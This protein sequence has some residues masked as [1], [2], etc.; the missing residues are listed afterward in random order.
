MGLINIGLFGLNFVT[1]GEA[2][3][4]RAVGEESIN[5]MKNWKTPGTWTTPK[6][7]GLGGSGE[8]RQ[9]GDNLIEWVRVDFGHKTGGFTYP[10]T[11]SEYYQVDDLAKV[12]PNSEGKIEPIRNIHETLD[13]QLPKDWWDK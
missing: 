2:G 5:A 11:N 6:T 12:F 7:F 10:H 8:A 4:A 13:P 1:E 3:E 9:V